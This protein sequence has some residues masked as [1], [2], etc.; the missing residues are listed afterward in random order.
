MIRPNIDKQKNFKKIPARKLYKK[1]YVSKHTQFNSNLSD[2]F[3]DKKKLVTFYTAFK[4]IK[5]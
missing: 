1:E 3:I 4:R 2:E 5:K